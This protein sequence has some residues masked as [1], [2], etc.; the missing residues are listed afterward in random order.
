MRREVTICTLATALAFMLNPGVSRAQSV[1]KG[2]DEAACTA[3]K[4]CQWRAARPGGMNKSPRK[5]HCRIDMRKV[6]QILKDAK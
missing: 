2:L 6:N 3:H 5:A 4:A 1:C